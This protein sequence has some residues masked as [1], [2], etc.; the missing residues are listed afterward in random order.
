M[1]NVGTKRSRPGVDI[2]APGWACYQRSCRQFQ[3]TFGANGCAQWQPRWT[4][5]W[6]TPADR[7]DPPPTPCRESSLTC[8]YSPTPVRR[9]P[10]ALWKRALV[11]LWRT[12]FPAIGSTPRR[13]RWSER[14]C[15]GGPEP[16]VLERAPWPCAQDQSSG[17]G[18]PGAQQVVGGQA[19]GQRERPGLARGRCTGWSPGRGAA[20]GRSRSAVH[21]PV[22]LLR[23]FWRC[24]SPLAAGTHPS[25]SV[26]RGGSLRANS[27]RS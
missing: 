4:A 16:A 19:Q 9:L 25:S 26:R 11:A 15:T 22:A 7:S 8:G 2:E 20:S 6:T 3:A 1:D 13:W 10:T 24:A 14:L 5:L 12:R 21:R 27:R 17:G 23:S 18:F